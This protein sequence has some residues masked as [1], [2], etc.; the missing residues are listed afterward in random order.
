MTGNRPASNSR[1]ITYNGLVRHNRSLIAL[2]LVLA[3]AAQGQVTYCKDIG[4][5]KTYCSGGT[6]IHRNDSTTI[7][8][9]SRQAPPQASPSLPNPLM[10][11]NA[12]PTLDAPYSAAGTQGTLPALPVQPPSQFAHPPGQA[13]QGTPVIILP[14]AGSR[15]CHQFGTTLVCN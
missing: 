6:I 13:P 10:Q 14:P 9:N 5:G 11:N 2:L 3:P 8:T 4:H 7:I 1:F 15:V 12:L